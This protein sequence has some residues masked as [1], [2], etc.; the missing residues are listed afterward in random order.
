M[1][2]NTTTITHLK[3]LITEFVAERDWQQFHDPKNL[4]MALSSEVGELADIFRWVSSDKSI[5]LATDPENKQAVANELA[6]VM[7]FA[8]EFASVCGIDIAEAIDAKSKINAE[9]YPVAKSKGSSKKYDR[10]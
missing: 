9:K 10:L 6:D 8:L 5:T 7:M 4:V 1:N 2:D 3:T